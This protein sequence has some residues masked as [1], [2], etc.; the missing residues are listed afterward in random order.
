MELSDYK[1]GVARQ[2]QYDDWDDMVK[3]LSSFGKYPFREHDIAAE[4]Y[5]KHVAKRTLEKYKKDGTK[6]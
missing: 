3:T 6:K 5:A 2:N 1:N 4:R